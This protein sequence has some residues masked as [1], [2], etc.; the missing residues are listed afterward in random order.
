MV[1]VTEITVCR[2]RSSNHPWVK[3]E[4]FRGWAGSNMPKNESRASRRGPPCFAGSR[5]VQGQ[6]CRR[7]HLPDPPG[8]HRV[9][10]ADAGVRHWRCRCSPTEYWLKAILIPVLIFLVGGAALQHPHRLRRAAVARLGGLHG[11][12][13]LRGLQLHAAHR[14]HALPGGAGAGGL[15]AAL[16]GICSAA[17]PAH[18][19]FYLAVATLAAQFF[20]VWALVKFPWFSNNSSSGVV[21]AQGRD[22][23]R[24][25]LRVALRRVKYVLTFLIVV[26]MAL[27]AR[28]WCA[29]PPAGPGW[30]CATWTWRP[31]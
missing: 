27:L 31:R 8:P 20:I 3:P 17:Q 15:T 16:V 29:A 9:L 12:G 1:G 6:W 11:G 30:R 7:P 13:G 21:T 4:A 10:G 18:Q 23:P 24:L 28:T 2:S 5:P 22:H 25:H 26:V 14:R 19:G